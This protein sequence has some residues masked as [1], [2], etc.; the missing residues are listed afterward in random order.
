MEAAP[1]PATGLAVLASV[2]CLEC[3]SVYAKPT[4]GG[5]NEM[6]PG[7]PLCGYVGWIPVRLALAPETRL[8]SGVGRQL[9][10]AGR[11]R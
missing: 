3:G 9:R 7:C 6:N 5:T 4:V 1:T 11:S 10:L 8:R 2:R